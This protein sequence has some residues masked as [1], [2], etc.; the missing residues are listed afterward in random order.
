MNL[1]PV[2]VDIDPKTMNL[3]ISHLKKVLDNDDNIKGI[4]AVHI[5]GMCTNME[6]LMKIVKEKNLFLIEDTC[7]SLGTTYKNKKLGT[8]GDF[9]TYSFYYSHH[10][11][12]IEGGMVVCNNK[13]DYNILKCLRAHGWTRNLDNKDL[14]EKKYNSIDSR[15][16]FINMGYNLRPM[17]IQGRMGI[18]QL[19]KLTEKNNNRIFNHDQVINKLLNDK[20]NNNIFSSPIPLEHT[21]TAWFGI[22]IIINKRYKKLYKKYLKYLDNNKVETR[23]IV[24]GN[25]AK[26]PICEYFNFDFSSSDMIGADIL[27]ETGFF[28]GSSCSKISDEKLNKLIEIFYNFD[29]SQSC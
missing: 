6:E 2:L 8:F 12:T 21:N 5:L 7:E 10:I 29:F 23:P 26:Q 9:G 16:L 24:S 4:M 11:T 18:I 14:Y 20:R 28:I 15:F 19:K 3:D 1:K 17:E 27:H 13:E 25:M 22:V